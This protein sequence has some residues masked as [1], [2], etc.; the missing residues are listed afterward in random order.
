VAVFP[1][2]PFLLPVQDKVANSIVKVGGQNCYFVDQ[3]AYTGAVSTC[4]LKD[5]G[6]THVLCGHSERRVLFADDDS[7]INKKVRKV[8]S[9][10]LVPVLCCGETK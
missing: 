8:L 2:H 5:I 1:P 4:M 10:G 7:L 3:G 6:V 9:E